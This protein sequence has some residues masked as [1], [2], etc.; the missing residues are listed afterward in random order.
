MTFNLNTRLA[1][2]LVI[3][4]LGM[5]LT[6]ATQT[7]DWQWF[8]RAGSVVVA[9][10]ILLT[11]SQIIEHGKR[12]RSRRL[13]WEAANSLVREKPDANNPLNRDWAQGDLVRQ[14]VHS[15]SRE[16]ETWINEG[17]GLY[18]LVGGTLIWGFGDL[19]GTAFG[20]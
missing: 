17:H 19:I 2:V 18:M 12:L 16:E 4:A 14:L 3:I 13:D 15:R 6:L 9:I 20:L 1:Y 10:G 8:S 7:G 11:S 5:G